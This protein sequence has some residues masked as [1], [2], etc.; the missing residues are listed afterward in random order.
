[1]LDY[2][3]L[4]YGQ[5]LVIGIFQ[6][7]AILP[8]LSRS[9]WTI[10]AGLLLGMRR[11][12][13]AA[14]SFLLAIPAIAGATALQLKDLLAGSSGGTP[15]AV[16]AVGTAVAWAVGMLSL[17]GLITIVRRG[18]LAAFAWYLFPMGLA[19]ILWQLL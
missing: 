1:A 9:G 19:V 2:Q 5:A 14:F 18:R 4:S 13:A 12:A 6:A 16:L 15:T 10:A 3:Q 7:A 17:W 11:D 8:G